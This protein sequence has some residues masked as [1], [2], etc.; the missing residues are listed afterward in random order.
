MEKE[1]LREPVVCVLGHV[2]HGKTT[3]LDAVRGTSIAKSEKG[4]ITQR[5]GA[6]EISR[7]TIQNYSK[8]ILG[9][10]KIRIPGLLFID[11]P[12]HVA[13][14]NMRARGGALADIAIL[15]VDINEG[16]KPQ[17]IESLNILKK[18]KT[19]FIVVANKIDMITM[20]RESKNTTFKECMSKQRPEWI[21]EFEKKFY[22][23]VGK[24]YEHGFSAERYDKISDFKKTLMIVP[25]SARSS[26]GVQ[27]VIVMLS[28][29]AQRFLESEI[30]LG[31]KETSAGTVIEVQREESLG[32]TLDTVLYQGTFRRGQSIALNTRQGTDTTKI[33]ALLVNSG[34]RGKGLRE[35]ESVHAASAVRILISDRL[36]VIPGTPVYGYEKPEE[37]ESAFEEIRR[38]T[39]PDIELSPVGIHVKADALGSLEALSYELMQRDIK[40]RFAGIGDIS[41]RDIVSTETVSEPLDRLIIGFNVEVLPDAQDS[42]STSDANVLTGNVIYSIVEETENWIK[43]KRSELLEEKK[44]DIPIPSKFSIMPEYIFRATKPVI[45][46]IKVHAGRVKVGDRLIKADGRYAGTIR[47]LRDGEISRK[48]CDAPGEVAAAIEGVTLNRQISPGETLYVDIPEGTVREIQQSDMDDSIIS[49]LD[50]I[51][52]I[53]RKE[54]MFWGTRA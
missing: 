53:K 2:D 8:G 7:S 10:T 44:H 39:Q 6:T 35:K 9:N 1:T 49:V 41:R 15:V 38:Q 30:S 26:V 43:Q 25:V 50:E 51:I 22:E 20:Y 48:F 27:D 28:G 14:A 37:K 19:P 4:G 46:G 45:V 40:I 23:L 11:T 31:E 33:K 18:F 5:I 32:L 21:A 29:V 12:G 42:L 52:R 34:N 16:L 36:E 47:S 24:L 17:T 54:D 13:F 3:F